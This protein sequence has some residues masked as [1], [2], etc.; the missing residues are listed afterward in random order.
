MHLLAFKEVRQQG[1]QPFHAAVD[2]VG[3]VALARLGAPHPD[4]DVVVGAAREAQR[5]LL[6]ADSQHVACI[7]VPFLDGH[8]RHRAVG[9]AEAGVIHL[10]ATVHHAE[11]LLVGAD[12]EV[13]RRHPH[14]VAQRLEADVDRPPHLARQAHPFGE[15]R[16][17]LHLRLCA[18][19]A[20]LLRNRA[21]AP[22]PFPKITHHRAYLP[23]IAS[24]ESVCLFCHIV[25]FYC[26]DAACCVS[27]SSP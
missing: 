2:G 12:E 18:R 25:L 1:A 9:D 3:Q 23:G 13:L 14:R 4:I 24:Q 17:V 5:V 10:E 19:I 15:Y 20:H 7:D 26:R 21:H 27:L 8:R 11:S 16:A 22:L 6:E